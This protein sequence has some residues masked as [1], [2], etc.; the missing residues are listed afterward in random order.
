MI[1]NFRFANG[2]SQSDHL[3]HFL[4][5]CIHFSSHFHA[6][7]IH[8]S[9]EVLGRT[10]QTA[11]VRPTPQKLGIAWQ[12][13]GI[14]GESESLGESRRVSESLGES[15]DLTSSDA[16]SNQVFQWDAMGNAALV[17]SNSK[18]IDVYEC[19]TWK[20]ARNC[21]EVKKDEKGITVG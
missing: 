19:R 18:F 13:T 11:D 6:L 2:S 3:A 12:L 8:F 17:A 1:W 20:I 21:K 14:G 15:Q 10:P 9:S 7:S 5:V 4:H 16:L